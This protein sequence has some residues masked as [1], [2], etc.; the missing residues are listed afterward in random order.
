MESFWRSQSSREM[1]VRRVRAGEARR[2]I[3]C[4]SHPPV[5]QHT[6]IGGCSMEERPQVSKTARP[7]APGIYDSDPEPFVENK[8]SVDL[9]RNLFYRIA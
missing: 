8:M 7:G 1:R 4:L 6:V 5:I 2:R 3:H 9:I